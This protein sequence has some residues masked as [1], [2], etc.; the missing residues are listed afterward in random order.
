M[1]FDDFFSRKLRINARPIAVDHRKVIFPCD[2]RHL[3]IED[4]KKLPSFFIKGQKFNLQMLLQN[5]ELQ[6][7][8]QN[9]TVV[10]SRLCPIDYHRF[11]FPC[12]AV[13]RKIYKVNGDYL[14]VHP[15]ATRSKISIFF[16][17][18]RIISVLQSDDVDQ[19]LMIEVGATCVGSIVQTAEVGRLYFKGEEKGFFS[20][21]GSTV[22][23]IF[24]EKKVNFAEDLRQNS[25]NG[26]ETFALMGDDMGVKI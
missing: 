25:M 7:R 11:H 6:K 13:I 26:V 17:N 8:F 5:D 14:S 3:L 24:Q 21:G 22:M 12:N 15:I 9:G 19:L 20:F 1:S 23:T 2:G 10:I 16:E 4:L 18:K